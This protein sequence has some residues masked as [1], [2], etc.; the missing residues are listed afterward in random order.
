[1][2][3]N[4]SKTGKSK[5]ERSKSPSQS[6]PVNLVTSMCSH[7]S[8]S[9]SE[10]IDL[11]QITVPKEVE[12][13]D[14][15][16]IQSRC[17]GQKDIVDERFAPFVSLGVVTSPEGE[18]K[19]T[20]ISILRDTGASQSLLLQGVVEIGPKT[21]TG[22]SVIITGVEGG[23]LSIPLHK[24]NL[25]S[26][27]V[28]GDVVVGITPTL[29]VAGV[30]LLLGNDLAGDK[31]VTDPVVTDNPV[32]TNCENESLAD[33][34]P[35]V[36]P[37]CVVTRSM[38]KKEEVNDS[39]KVELGKTFMVDLD[40]LLA[41]KESKVQFTRAG[42]VE[43]QT[44]DPDLV[45]LLEKAMTPEEAAGETKCFFLQTGVLMRKWT[46]PESP[47]D[48][49][50]EIKHQIVVPSEF[51]PHV[52]ELAHETP[53]AGHL[54]VNKSTSRLL[55]HFW[56]PGVRKSVVEHC[57]CCHVCQVVGKPNQNPPKAPLHPIPA[58]D[59]PF[60]RV[61]IDCVGPLPRTSAG[62]EYL[63]TIMCASSRFPEAIPLRNIKTQTIVKALF[64]FFTQ[65]GLPKT[66]QS[67]QGSNFTAHLF[68]QVMA[69]L[70]IIHVCSS[71]YHPQSQGALER[72]HQTFKSMMRTYVFQHHKDWDLGVPYLLFASRDSVQES[73]GFTPFELVFGH[74]V[75]GPLK[76]VKEKWLD[77]ED[78]VTDLL[79]YVTKMKERLSEVCSLAKDNLKVTQGQMKSWYDSDARER[80]FKVG[81][82]VLILLP[83]PG[84]SLQARFTGPCTVLQKLGD[85]DYVVSTPER[86]KK[87]QKCHVNMMK[88][89]YTKDGGVVSLVIVD[90][91][92][93]TQAQGSDFEV[94]PCPIKLDNSKVLANF[95]TKV[96]HLDDDKGSDLSDLVL[97]F[98]HLFPDV[99]GKARG[100]EHDVDVGDAAPIKQHPYRLG[101]E[102][103]E[104]M[105]KEVE[106]M[107]KNDIIE[108]CVSDW[109]SPCL[110]IPKSDGSWRFC[111]DYRKV[112]KVTRTDSYPMP[113]V[114]DCIDQIGNTRFVSKLDLLKGYW[115]VPLTERA[116][117]ISA[118]ATPG[119]LYRYKVTPFGMKNSGCTFQR[120][121]NQVV[122]GLKN[123]RVYVDDIIVFSDTWEEHMAALRA[124]FERLAEFGLTVNLVKSEFGKATVQFLGYVVGQGQVLPVTAK[125][126][127]I[128]DFKAPTDKKG[129]MRFLG[130]I[131][132]YRRFCCNFSDVVAPL[133]NLLGDRVKFT[134]TPVCQDAFDK[135]KRILM[136]SPVL[137]APDFDKSFKLY[138][139]ASDVG[140]GSVLVQEDSQGIEHPVSFYSKKLDKCQRNYSTIEKEALSLLL[141]LKH[142]SVYVE[143]S[144]F[145][146]QVFTDHNPLTFVHKMKTKNQRLLRWSLTLQEYNIEISHVKGKDNIVADALSRL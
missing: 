56:W 111:T 3:A 70:G 22:N 103:Q 141:A 20:T 60:S 23:G 124:L 128:C 67:D 2:A 134:W 136:D 26:G 146:L 24:V 62:N 11:F 63:L 113:R 65:Y 29:P 4:T 55:E 89:Y 140:I 39:S 48:H 9:L 101:P 17:A 115:Q 97:E 145:T 1:M 75:R 131:G 132:F 6:F 50:W 14:P 107:L 84:N 143:S 42:L 52:L 53:M 83:I 121:T 34:F 35:G 44:T 30:Q 78:E 86:R 51:R 88:P 79:T 8:I 80:Q 120:L 46:P 59:E 41:G 126:Q 43:A 118:F 104:A 85:L 18:V 99:P 37:A 110:L 106:Y 130:M 94:T 105:R 123:T 95:K 19:K 109:S 25:E 102:K 68:D 82:R 108:P 112:N 129:L 27:L 98:E 119:G 58:F 69:E 90:K 72:Y 139:D 117:N 61:I 45:P 100:A 32:D 91:P 144:K 15:V 40:T 127:T 76:L 142:F 74:K 135:V 47:A 13:V 38:A 92:N 57:R 33:D 133:T 16:L 116:K 36:F 31:V 54:G 71:A 93:E 28:S 138:C 137:M 21:D 77:A 12:Q 73:L 125:V 81:D 5:R 87:T 64:K 49:E 114:D 66:V 96:S 10:S 7:E 122:F